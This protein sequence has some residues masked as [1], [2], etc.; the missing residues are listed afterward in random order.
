MPRVLVDALLGGQA[1]QEVQRE[2]DVQVLGDWQQ[3]L[4]GNEPESQRI[5]LLQ[6]EAR[7]RRLALD[8]QH[9]QKGAPKFSVGDLGRVEK[10]AAYITENYASSLKIDE[11]AAVVG[12][13]P[14]YAMSLFRRE[15]GTSLGDFITR[16]RLSHAQ[17]LLATTGR[18]VLDIAFACGFGSAS[19][20]H[21]AF[22][23][24]FGCSPAQYRRDL[25]ARIKE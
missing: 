15:F 23:A 21:S 24:S 25:R 10:M 16:Y 13:H 8:L 18:G 2:T 12:V 1:I 9:G 22:K 20:F 14:N 19:R 6:L 5:M 17:R 3:D 7:L 11:I 4:A